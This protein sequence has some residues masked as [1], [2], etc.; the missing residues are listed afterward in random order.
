MNCSVAGRCRRLVGNGDES[1]GLRESGAVI[2]H[3]KVVELVGATGAEQ[4]DDVLEMPRVRSK[5]Y[6]RDCRENEG[7]RASHAP[8]AR[9]IL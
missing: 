1:R 3:V 9:E 2:R 5:S 6:C 8:M 7:K 4:L